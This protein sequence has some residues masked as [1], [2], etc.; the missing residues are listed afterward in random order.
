MSNADADD[1]WER[2]TAARPLFGAPPADRPL[3][4]LNMVTSVDGATTIDGRVGI[5]TG[6]VDQAL[7]Y[8]LRAEADAV[9][10]GAGTVRAEGYGALLPADQRRRRAEERGAAEPLLCVVTSLPALP[11][12]APA[13]GPS[14]SPLVFLTGSDAPLPA[15][16]R[17]LLAI[18]PAIPGPP[19]ASL[20]LAPLLSR[21]RDE[22]GVE[23][24]VCEGGP[25]LNASL[26]AEDL[27]DEAFV[28]VSPLMAQERA[29]PGMVARSAPPAS[30]ELVACADSGDF[31][32]LRYRTRR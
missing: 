22:L 3:V 4:C 17:T 27:V 24:V 12:D 29:S 11:D 23:R 25:T 20:V 2:L 7:L 5:L 30:L 31:V 19:T 18:R 14:P 6:P 8:R 16:A 21:L 10:V 15:A 1:V 28:S 26:F 32:F 9:L 13:L